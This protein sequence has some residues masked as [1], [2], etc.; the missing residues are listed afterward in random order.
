MGGKCYL[1]EVF[2]C[3]SLIMMKL[4][5][6]HMFNLLFYFLEIICLLSFDHFLFGC[7]S[8]KIDLWEVFCYIKKAHFSDINCKYFLCLPFF[9][10]MEVFAMKEFSFLCSQLCW[11]FF[12]FFWL[13]GFVSY[14]ERTSY[15]KIILKII[16][17]SSVS[18]GFIFHVKTLIHLEFIWPRCELW[19]TFAWISP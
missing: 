14:L 6:C 11:T 13:L 15:S 18:H 12:F 2:I 8:F 1:S 19:T 4:S 16:S 7:W 17:F 10:L 9:N 5:N 3:I